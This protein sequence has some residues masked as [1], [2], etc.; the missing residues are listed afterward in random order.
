M[1]I[2]SVYYEQEKDIEIKNTKAVEER[3][4]NNIL[5]DNI[6]PSLLQNNNNI[7]NA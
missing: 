4:S 1:K 7:D 6:Y 2:S 3:L 5:Q